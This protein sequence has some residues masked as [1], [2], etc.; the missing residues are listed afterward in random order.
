MTLC[1]L[2]TIVSSIPFLALGFWPIAG[3]FGLDFLGALHRVPSEFP[4]GESFEQLEL[5]RSI[6]G[7]PGRLI[8][9]SEGMAV[10]SALDP[11]RARG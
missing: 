2:A 10:Q 6:P 7:P 11:P 5:T 8:A 1:C 9:A 3:F 4:P